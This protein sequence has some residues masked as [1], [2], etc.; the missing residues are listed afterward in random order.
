MVDRGVPLAKMRFV[1][2]IVATMALVLSLLVP[3]NRAESSVVFDPGFIITDE[4]FYD[5]NAMS[6]TEIQSFL[7]LKIGACANG[8]CL[9]VAVLPVA[10]RA[11]RYSQSTGALICSAIAGGEMRASELIYRTQVACGISAKVILVTLQKE[12]GLVTDQAPSS[13]ALRAAMGMGCPDTAPCDTAFEGLATQIISGT[14]QLK[15]YK[16]AAFARQ[17]GVHFI[18]FF[19]SASCGGTY[20]NIRNY[21]TAALYNYTPYQPNAAAIANPYR[22]GD[23]CSS[24]GNRN[25][26][27]YYTDWFGSPVGV[28]LPATNEPPFVLGRDKSGD[29][30]LYGTNGSGSWQPKV[31]V[32]QGWD[33]MVGV[34]IAGD[35]NGD[36]LRDIFALDKAGVLW[37]YPTDGWAGLRARVQ[38][39]TGWNSVVGLVAPGD[40]TGDGREDLIAITSDGAMKL[41]PGDGRGGLRT[42]QPLGSGWN[43]ATA[44]LGVGDFDGDGHNDLMSVDVA[45]RLSLHGGTGAGSLRPARQIGTDWNT[46]TAIVGVRDFDGSG[47][48]DVLS[49]DM[50]GSLWLYRGNGSGGWLGRVLVGSGW[51]VMDMIVGS[52]DPGRRPLLS[53][54]VGDVNGDG[55]R[56]VIAL[57]ASGSLWLYPGN[58]SG[59]LGSR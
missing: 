19:T 33:Q 14:G 28:P 39:A 50:A 59:G 49:R 35:V 42:A 5:S 6:A 25:F 40:M 47:T 38:V 21:A 58:G 17:P 13:R 29:L 55:S 57:D 48:A 41:Y 31:R 16:A 32:G 46:M 15:A 27:N 44:V 51:N 18:D 8:M 20:V 9:N 30:W 3:A 53:P 24:Y 52:G 7:D 34:A 43:L 22:L 1:C 23:N 12:Q 36:V 10:A 26:F 37:L 54:G 45:G 4:L 11:A 56:D 2:V